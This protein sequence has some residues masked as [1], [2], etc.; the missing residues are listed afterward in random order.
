MS[1]SLANKSLSARMHYA[2]IIVAVTF[3]TSVITAGTLGTAG[4]LLVPL[5]QEFGWKA[6]DVSSAFGMRLALFGLLGPFAA[7]MMNR[8]GVRRMVTIA[9]L[10]ILSGLVGSLFINT[11]WQLFI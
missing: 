4:I 2:W 5:E 1:M 8:F 7:A 9:L 3:M 6:S 11:V 10:I